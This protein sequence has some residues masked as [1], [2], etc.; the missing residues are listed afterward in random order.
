MG[1]I[2][3]GV[4]VEDFLDFLVGFGEFVLAEFDK[5][6]GTFELIGQSVDVEF[7]V[8]HLSDDGF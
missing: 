2:R 1:L 7:I 3:G 4:L 8:L 6:L 5:L